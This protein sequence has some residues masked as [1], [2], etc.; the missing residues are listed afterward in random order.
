VETSITEEQE[1]ILTT[2]MSEFNAKAIGQKQTRTKL[3]YCFFALYSIRRWSNWVG[4]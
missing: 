4:L 2:V 1:V 3:G